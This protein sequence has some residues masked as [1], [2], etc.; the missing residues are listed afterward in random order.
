MKNLG[1]IHIL[2]L[3]IAMLVCKCV[4]AQDFLVTTKGDTIFGEIKPLNYGPEKKVLIKTADKKKTVYSMFQVSFY[5]LEKE[6]YYPVKGPAGYSFMKLL[7]PGYLSLYGFQVE[8]QTTYDGR[9]LLKRDGKGTEVPNLSFKKALT[10]FLD[11]CDQVAVKIENGVFS[12]RD[13][14]KIVDEYNAC[15][16][17]NTSERLP[18]AS[19]PS[20]KKK[21]DS[22]DVLAEKVKAHENF[23]GQENTLEMISEIKSKISKSEKVPNFLIQGLKETLTI[24]ELQ[25]DLQNALN[26]IPQ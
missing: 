3:L 11:D 16:N 5:S 15:I 4:N 7:K 2:F 10:N 19:T 14:E 17:S 21:T 12:K 25:E 23:D 6:T 18:V 9:F 24:P 20:L 1:I 8:N 26:E 22:W 13:L